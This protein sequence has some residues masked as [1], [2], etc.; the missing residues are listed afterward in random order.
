MTKKGE[1]EKPATPICLIYSADQS[2]SN[3]TV[4]GECY[5]VLEGGNCKKVWI[6]RRSVEHLKD[7][8]LLRVWCGDMVFAMGDT[9]PTPYLFVVEFPVPED[10]Y[11]EFVAWYREEHVPM[12]LANPDWQGT[13]LYRA[14]IQ[15]TPF[16]FTSVHHLS[17]P[18]ALDSK[19]RQASRSTPWF[20][21]LKVHSWFDQGFNRWLL[22]F[23]S[24]EERGL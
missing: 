6:T 1:V 9:K 20:F 4:P 22:K 19:E 23:I 5:E 15:E 7:N 12:L 11:T 21:R 24:G 18:R 14:N 13:E 16:S 8:C 2:Q 17:H 10:F 3:V